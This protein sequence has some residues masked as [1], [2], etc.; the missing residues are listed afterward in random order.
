LQRNAQ[1]TAAQNTDMLKAL[2]SRFVDERRQASG[3]A[4]LSASDKETLFEQFRAWQRG[5]A[6]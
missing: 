5:Q 6:R 1:V 4:P 2:F 3:N